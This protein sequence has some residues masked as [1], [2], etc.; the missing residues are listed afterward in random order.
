MNAEKKLTLCSDK[1]SDSASAFRDLK[2]FFSV[3]GF[4]LV[5]GPSEAFLRVEAE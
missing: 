5:M 1:A 3:L 4:F 2:L